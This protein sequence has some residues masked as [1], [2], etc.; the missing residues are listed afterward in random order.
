MS[1]QR[2][3]LTYRGLIAPAADPAQ[4]RERLTQIFKL[5][6][7]GVE[8][9]FTGKP[10]VVKRDVDAA[11]AAQFEKIF[12]RAGAVLTVTPIDSPG[13]PIEAAVR[14][15]SSDIGADSGSVSE[16]NDLPPFLHRDHAGSAASAATPSGLSL[17]PQ[18]GDLEEA[19]PT[20][21]PD[22]DISYLSLVAGSDW[23]L[24][25][26]EPPP[27]PVPEPDLSYLALEPMSEARDDPARPMD[28]DLL[29][30]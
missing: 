13:G 23:T 16:P 9:L 4:T 6:E 19:P 12:A 25:D 21:A 7:K 30:P 15:D 11:T 3:D 27:T 26:C 18:F 8:R 14:P 17:A 10:V 20:A 1:D 5:N 22:I 2:F 29:G 28:P 24:E